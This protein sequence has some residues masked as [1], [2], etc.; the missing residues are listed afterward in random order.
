MLITIK[1][2]RWR[3]PRDNFMIFMCS[4]RRSASEILA[5]PIYIHQTRHLYRTS[6]HHTAT[7][8]FI[9]ITRWCRSQCLSLPLEGVSLPGHDHATWGQLTQFKVILASKQ[10]VYFTQLCPYYNS[11]TNI[12][13]LKNIRSF[14]GWVSG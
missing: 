14:C 10:D 2:D 4:Y 5:P 3:G 6:S 13:R 1:A 8:V 12:F 9:A 11:P 7:I